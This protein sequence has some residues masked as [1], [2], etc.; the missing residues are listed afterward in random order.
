M[1]IALFE[2]LACIQT[3]D[4]TGADEAYLNVDG[5]RAWGPTD[6]NDGETE[7]LGFFRPFSGSLTVDLFDEDWPDADDFLGRVVIN[8]SEADGTRHFQD[9]T[10]DDAHYTLY[11]RVLA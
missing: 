4:S 2:D 9:F 8:Q 1:A 5:G 6:I 7:H 3:E 10:L 11:Y